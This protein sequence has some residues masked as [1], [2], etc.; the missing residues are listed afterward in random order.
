M[1][2][3]NIEIE[4][5]GVQGGH[6]SE[7]GVFMIIVYYVDTVQFPCRIKYI[8][9]LFLWSPFNGNTLS[10]GLIEWLDFSTKTTKRTRFI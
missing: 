10:G 4:N 9:P 5:R 7:K 8:K 2:V 6:L 3:W 1:E